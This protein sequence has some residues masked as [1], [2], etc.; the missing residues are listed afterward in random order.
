MLAFVLVYILSLINPVHPQDAVTE[1]LKAALFFMVYWLAACAAA[2][3]KGFKIVLGAAYLAALGLGGQG[4]GS[5]DTFLL[6]SP[7]ALL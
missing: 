3:E 7:G 6:P 1:V 5:P 2:D 4:D